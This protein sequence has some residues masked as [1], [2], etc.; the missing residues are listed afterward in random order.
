MTAGRGHDGAARGGAAPRVVIAGGGV[1]AAE[2]LLALAALAPGRADVELLAVE[3]DMVLAPPST[4]MPFADVPATSVPLAPLA[5]RAGA[6]LRRGV[7]ASVDTAHRVA[8]TAGGS[9]IDYDHLVIAVG[10]RRVPT[11]AEGAVTFG[12]PQD[13]PAVRNLLDLIEAG[14]ARGVT[15]R[16]AVVV[17]PG[18]G[19][20]LPAYEI[21]FLAHGHLADAGLRDRVGVAI[22]TD[23][24]RPLAAFGPEASAAVAA[25]LAQAD[26]AVHTSSV[27]RR[28]AWGRLELAP[29]AEVVVDRVVSLP[30]LR[31]PHL[32]GVPCDHL[33]F[34]RTTPEG[35][36]AGL[37]DVYA[38]GDAGTFP[39]K[40]GGIACQQA[41]AV[42]AAIAARL[43]APVAEEPFAP[44][45]R[46]ILWTHDGSRFM[47][48]DVAGG[49][50]ESRGVTSRT[51]PLWWPP[52]KLA[53]RYLAPY[54]EGQEGGAELVDL[55]PGP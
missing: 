1:A 6:H 39:L 8:V 46:G 31:G 2:L 18:P 53:C 13:V 35:R 23:E 44:T 26:I 40:Q 4:A 21:A 51:D 25:D 17:P 28:W 48:A 42:A 16:L 37:D 24:D 11:L 36:V 34:V 12:G 43:G 9:R 54:L 7:L 20:P 29:H 52:Q 47:R 41:D 49:A 33:G 38:I 10:A 55:A 3:D 14:A 5:K 30:A 27:V 50:D 15:T 45:L 22:V 32:P 19:W